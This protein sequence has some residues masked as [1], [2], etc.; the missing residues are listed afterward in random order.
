M[1]WAGVN[2][3]TNWGKGLLGV[4]IFH[5]GGGNAVNSQTHSLQVRLKNGVVVNNQIVNS[6][7]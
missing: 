2:S 7:Y 4:A 5:L 6:Q 3:T 1:I